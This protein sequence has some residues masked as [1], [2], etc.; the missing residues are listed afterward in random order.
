MDIL[1]THITQL[2]NKLQ[3]LLKNYVQ[4]QKENIQL[5][6]NIEKKETLLQ[7]KSQ[8]IQDFQQ[9]VDSLKITK[10]GW[11]NEDKKMLQRRIDQYLKEIDICLASL[12]Q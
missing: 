11:V 12:N 2:Q 7:V 10:G 8:Q 9:Q 1:S 6:K 5:R 3:L 4:L